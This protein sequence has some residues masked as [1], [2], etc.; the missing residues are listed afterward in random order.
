MAG[1]FDQNHPGGHPTKCFLTPSA[2]TRDAFNEIDTTCKL[3]DGASSSSSSNGN[4]VDLK[5]TLEVT[6]KKAARIRRYERSSCTRTR[7]AATDLRYRRR[8]REQPVLVVNARPCGVVITGVLV[9]LRPLYPGI[10]F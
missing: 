1:L 10:S 8:E 6:D 7:T 9:R 4:Y 2:D 5:V 3:I